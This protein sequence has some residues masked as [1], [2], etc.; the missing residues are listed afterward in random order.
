[1]EAF[2]R[3]MEVCEIAAASAGDK[4]LLARAIGPFQDCDAPAAFAGLDSAH[5]AGGSGAQ[6]YGIKF[7]DHEREVCRA[8]PAANDYYMIWASSKQSLT[9][10]SRYYASAAFALR[11]F[12]VVEF[13]KSKHLLYRG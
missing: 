4:D 13:S 5:Q 11:S 8:K 2:R 6:N 7:V 9:R 3:A 10:P 12:S 1:M